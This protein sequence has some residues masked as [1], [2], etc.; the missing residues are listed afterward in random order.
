MRAEKKIITSEYVARL[1]ASP[2]F[3]VVDYVGLSVAQFSELRGRLRAAGA[4]VHVVKNSIFRIAA[5]EAGVGDLNGALT[6]QLAVVTGKKDVTAAAKVVKSFSKEFEKPVIKFG[7]LG[8]RRLEKPDV[9]ALADLPSLDSLRAGIIGL[10]EAPLAGLMG[11]LEA[12]ARDVVG[13]LRAR[14][15]KEGAAPA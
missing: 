15:E 14:L 3:I 10:L 9:E 7:F 12:P 5:K 1:N 2:F 6:G 8:N 4:E 13:V 11:V